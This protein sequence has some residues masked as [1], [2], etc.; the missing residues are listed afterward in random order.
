ME[1]TSANVLSCVWLFTTV[2]TVVHQAPLSMELPRQEYWSGLPFPPSGDLPDLGIKPTSPTLVSQFFLPLHQLGSPQSYSSVQFSHSV[3]SDSLQPHELQHSRLPCPSPT[4]RASSN[5]CQ[6]RW[7]CHPTISP[8]VD[9]FSC[10][11]SFPAS[12]SIPMRQFF[13]STVQST[14]V[15]TSASVLPVNI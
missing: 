4:P 2:G 12:G 7:W 6:S 9:P 5:T 13:T 8:S 14:G 15:S 3:M 1:D 11:Q 10:L